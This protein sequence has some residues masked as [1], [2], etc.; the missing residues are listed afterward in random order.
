MEVSQND[1]S[2]KEEQLNQNQ[3]KI[4]AFSLK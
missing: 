3:P 4:N 1:S 2:V